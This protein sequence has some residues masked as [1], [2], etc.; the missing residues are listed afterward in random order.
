MRLTK[1]YPKN[2]GTQLKQELALL[3][4][5]R[6]ILG[7]KYKTKTGLTKSCPKKI[8][9]QIKQKRTLQALLKPACKILE[10]RESK[11]GPY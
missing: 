9:T 10:P 11:N 5:A 6:Q 8:G 2:F 3:R 4:P 1:T 7:P